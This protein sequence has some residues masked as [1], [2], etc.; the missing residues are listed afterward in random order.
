MSQDHAIQ[1]LLDKQAITEVLYRYARS[2]DRADEELMHSCFHADS[3]HRHGRYD[4]PS[5]DFVG[6]AMGI[7]R[8][9][10]LERHQ[11]TN[12]MIELDGDT[13]FSEC[14][15]EAYHRQ[16]NPDTGE[17]EDYFQG[18]RF[19]DRLERRDGEWRIA[20]RIGL[21]DFERF[22]S[23][24]ERNVPKLPPLARSKRCPDDELYSV[25]L[26]RDRSR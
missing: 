11:I 16:P 23:I 8:G 15:Y 4:G 22:D 6:F 18:G 12:V 3:T 24:A 26:R 19:I 7:I 1:Q 14:Q 10:K 13:A 20:A 9:T 2:C 5:R 25:I 21:V 17:D